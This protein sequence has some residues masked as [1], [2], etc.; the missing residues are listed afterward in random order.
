MGSCIGQEPRL[1]DTT[2]EATSGQKA[3]SQE[4][5]QIIFSYQISEFYC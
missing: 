3:L 1:A 5:L 2:D 4:T